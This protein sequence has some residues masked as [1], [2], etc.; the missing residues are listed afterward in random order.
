[1]NVWSFLVCYHVHVHFV[2]FD[3]TVRWLSPVSI[4]C[5]VAEYASA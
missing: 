5:L 1:M 2:I 4:W 3:L